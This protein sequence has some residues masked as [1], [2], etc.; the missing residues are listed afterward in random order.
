LDRRKGSQKKWPQCHRL[1][2]ISIESHCRRFWSDQIVH[3]KRRIFIIY[4]QYM[5]IHNFMFSSLT[6]QRGRSCSLSLRRAAHGDKRMFLELI[7]TEFRLS[8]TFI[9]IIIIIVYVHN[10]YH[11]EVSSITYIH[12][13]RYNLQCTVIHGASPCFYLPLLTL[14]CSPLLPFLL[15]WNPPSY[16]RIRPPRSQVACELTSS[17]PPFSPTPPP[18]NSQN[19]NYPAPH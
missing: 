19:P 16:D 3:C 12:E 1:N 4:I 13:Y 2:I 18:S 5:Y 7:H 14:L 6:G 10:W 11:S 17:V 15:T 9:P 8:T